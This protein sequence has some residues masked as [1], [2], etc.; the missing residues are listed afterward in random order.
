MTDNN[1][2][3]KN[4][5]NDHNYKE[6]EHGGL[7]SPKFESAEGTRESANILALPLVQGRKE[8]LQ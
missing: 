8:K 2:V 7:Y 4:K 6:K 1:K 3:E 5:I